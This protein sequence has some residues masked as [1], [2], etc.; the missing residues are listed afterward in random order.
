MRRLNGYP[1]A[2]TRKA[3]VGVIRSRESDWLALLA[4]RTLAIG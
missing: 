3:L 4:R 1:N 2:S